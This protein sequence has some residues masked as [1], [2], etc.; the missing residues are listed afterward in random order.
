LPSTQN[1][2]IFPVDPDYFTLS[3]RPKSTSRIST[4]TE[5]FPISRHQSTMSSYASSHYQTK[6]AYA[7]RPSVKPGMLL[8][9][10][11]VPVY[12]SNTE[13]SQCPAITHSPHTLRTAT[14]AGPRPSLSFTSPR[15]RSMT[16]THPPQLVTLAITA[17]DLSSFPVKTALVMT[18]RGGYNQRLVRRQNVLLLHSVDWC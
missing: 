14:E 2:V 5:S 11:L 3:H 8:C 7:Q 17:R 13:Q 12:E 9:Y 4:V 18:G 15:A 6:G 1:P 16:R 10:G